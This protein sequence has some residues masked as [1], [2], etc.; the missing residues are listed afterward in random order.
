[1]YFVYIRSS[2]IHTYISVALIGVGV[3]DICHAAFILHT[4]IACVR[5]KFTAAMRCHNRLW[6]DCLYV[7]VK[8]QHAWYV[9]SDIDSF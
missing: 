3:N 4:F 7:M 1:M 6:Q 5:I 9:I 8:N 2:R